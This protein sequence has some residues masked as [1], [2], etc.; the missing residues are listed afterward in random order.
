M[1]LDLSMPSTA[2]PIV[3]VARVTKVFRDFW[4][5]RKA[6]ALDAVTFQVQRGEVFGLLGP[7]GSGKSTTLKLLL[8]LLHPNSGTL[9]LFGT[10]PSDVRIKARI[11]YMPEGACLYPY[12][13]AGETLDLYGRLLGLPAE[14]R[15][16]RSAQLLEMIGLTHARRRAVGEFSK[17]MARRLSLAQALLNDPDLVLLD[18]PTAGLDPVGCRQ[19]KELIGKLAER[20]KTVV[21]CSH[22]LADVED[23]CHRIAILYNGR[24]CVQGPM[25][26]LLRE[27][28]LA[29]LILPALPPAALADVRQHIRQRWGVAAEVDYPARRLEDL[30]L[31]T[32]AQAETRAG[33]YSGAR[34]QS[35]LAPFLEG[36]GSAAP[37]PSTP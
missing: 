8:G 21:L 30:F 18:E 9:R 12:L 22:L 19:F 4:G 16:A 10:P 15:R 25:R 31:E 13:T 17:G 28:T 29:R 37:P 27:S 11:G 6:L 23:V 1:S 3:D 35:E 32:I 26:D 36:A 7:N 33:D 24:L 5:R 14:Q 2:A 20:G 34:P